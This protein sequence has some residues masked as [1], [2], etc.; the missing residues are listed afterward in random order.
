MGLKT[1]FGLM[2]EMQ[3]PGTVTSKTVSHCRGIALAEHVVVLGDH[4]GSPALLEAMTRQ[5]STY[6][7]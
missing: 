1:I 4:I 3:P 7:E 5:G 2:A 6:E